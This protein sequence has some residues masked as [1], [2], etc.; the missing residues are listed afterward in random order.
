[1]IDPLP[2]GYSVKLEGGGGEQGNLFVLRPRE[3]RVAT[4]QFV[5]PAGFAKLPRT[6]DVVAS[7][8]M[9]VDNQIIGG[10]SARLAKANVKVPP[11]RE[12]QPR[13]RLMTQAPAQPAPAPAPAPATPNTDVTLNV[14]A[15]PALVTRTIASALRERQ[16][17]VAQVD[18]ERGL[19]SSGPIPLNGAQ[20]REAVTAEFFRGLK[21]GT[22]RHYVSFKIDRAADE[23]SQVIVSVRIVLEKAEVNS[24]IGGRARTVEWQ[25]RKAVQRDC[26]SSCAAVEVG[27]FPGDGV[28]KAVWPRLNG[29]A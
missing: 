19:V 3:I 17:P 27:A 22:G 11:P 10:L 18:E 24:P 2:K 16:L 1:M 29:F 25:S 13:P 8:S 6:N 20:M 28:S 26:Y 14:S 23:R 7:I 5:R 21:E 9:Q 4:A 15:A 12:V